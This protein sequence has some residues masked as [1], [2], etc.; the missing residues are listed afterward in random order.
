MSNSNEST[1][2]LITAISRT[3]NVRLLAKTITSVSA[4]AN[5][6]KKYCNLDQLTTDTPVHVSPVCIFHE[7]KRDNM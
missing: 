4:E 5:P 6:S 1:E 2:T 7:R 3:K